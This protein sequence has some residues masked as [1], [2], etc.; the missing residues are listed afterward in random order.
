MKYYLLDRFYY[1]HKMK[2]QKGS[3]SYVKLEQ[4]LKQRI[5]ESFPHDTKLLDVTFTVFDLETTGFFP[6]LGDAVVS[7]GAVKMKGRNIDRAET[8]YDVVKPITKIPTDI[9]HLT[10]IQ[11]SS[12]KYGK[13][14]PE[15]FFDFLSFSK[16]SMLV[17][18]PAS[19][20][21]DFLK[22][23]IGRWGLPPYEPAFLDSFS[24]AGWLDPNRNNRLDALIEAYQIEKL[25]R[26]HALNDAIMTARLFVEMMKE[27]ESRGIVTVGD[28]LN[29]CEESEKS[30]SL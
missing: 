29:K 8:F 3:D 14:F 20:D 19:F 7:I 10:G 6:E 27:A 5:P 4:T 22:K 15:S 25:D 28:L 18:H 16:G 2:H 26:H 21:I 30:T 1:N 13:P 12:I 17:A 24:V 23:L 9:F 11:K